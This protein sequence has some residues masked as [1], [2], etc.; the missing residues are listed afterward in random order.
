[1]SN[2]YF[3]VFRKIYK[4]SMMRPALAQRII[5]TIKA[6][7]KV[8]NGIILFCQSI[9]GVSVAS[10]FFLAL[11]VVFFA[12]GIIALCSTPVFL[13]GM[14]QE[15]LDS[16]FSDKKSNGEGSRKSE[17]ESKLKKR[18]EAVE[19][20]ENYLLQFLYPSIDKVENFPRKGPEVA[21]YLRVSTTRQ[22]REGESL[23]AQEDE[24]RNT[25]REIRA[26]RVYWIIDAGKSVKDF[27]SK[28][29]NTILNL[30]V[31]G[32]ITKFLISEIDRVGRKSLELLG[33][34]LQLRAYGVVIVTPNGEL[35]LKKLGDFIIAAVK[36]FSA[37]EENEKRAHC[38]L[39][40][41]VHAFRNRRWNLA[42]P[43]GYRKTGE[44]IEK[45][46]GWAPIISDIF[47]FFLR[48]K[49]Y[50]AVT[51]VL[52]EKHRE[53]LK[54]SL[55]RQQVSRILQNSVYAGK[56]RYS[57]K[58]VE[59]KFGSVVVDDPFLAYVSNDIFGK[60][61]E[62]VSNKHKKYMRRKKDLVELMESCGIEVLN[63]LP[64]VAPI[65]P[66]CEGI[67]KNNGPSYICQ[68]CKRQLEV[69]KKKEVEKI[70]EWA[71][72]RQ[73]CLKVLLKILSRY[74]EKPREIL[75]KIE[76]LDLSIDDF[77]EDT[78]NNQVEV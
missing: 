8:I 34:L 70:L 23:E 37:Q 59:K 31:A 74:K 56:P 33:F 64:Q 69:P 43:I 57:G 28:K 45:A 4:I 25:A 19:K 26:S 10:H 78:S 15:S 39:R 51:S 76:A 58:V 55:T 21:A 16:F 14:M 50:Q 9:F 53:F 61:Q 41:K 35:D 44:W 47:N 63:F 20:D 73:K 71:L 68:N 22:V 11:L 52:N 27:N 29:L 46:L 77:Q 75:Q 24:L 17:R 65:C 18:K 30:A 12:G 40:S 72:G 60:A 38:A 48:R 6:L 32:K 36:A 3:S 42:V 7:R 66:S 49:N 62:I 5:R 13:V 67:M 54:K 1:M 2:I